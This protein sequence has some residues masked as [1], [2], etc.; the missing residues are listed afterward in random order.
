MHDPSVYQ[1]N[2]QYY[3]DYNKR[4]TEC[5]CGCIVSYGHLSR[6]RKSKKHKIITTKKEVEAIPLPMAKLEIV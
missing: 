3:Q 2:K 4:R 5:S 6:H 1:N